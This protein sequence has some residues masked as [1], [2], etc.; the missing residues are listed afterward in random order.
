LGLL[1]IG[2]ALTTRTTAYEGRLTSTAPTS[3]AGLR[4]R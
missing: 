2:A 4:Q 3:D 1:E